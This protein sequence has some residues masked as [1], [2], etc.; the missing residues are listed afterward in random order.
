MH[1]TVEVLFDFLDI[2]LGAGEPFQ[3]DV[4]FFVQS[5]DFYPGI[6]ASVIIEHG[7][8]FLSVPF[9]TINRIAIAHVS[10]EAI[11]GTE[12]VTGHLV[13]I[14][15]RGLVAA[16]SSRSLRGWSCWPL[17]KDGNLIALDGWGLKGALEVHLR[18]C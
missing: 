8:G 14:H 2:F 12:F 4:K 18:T 17:R 11:H 7:L 6:A 10:V 1:D 9:L 3:E 16:E 13:T 15:M 5:D